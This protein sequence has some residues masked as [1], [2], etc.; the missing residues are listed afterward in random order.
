MCYDL[1][2]APEETS[3]ERFKGKGRSR[4]A[5]RALR[6]KVAAIADRTVGYADHVCEACVSVPLMPFYCSVLFLWNWNNNWRR[7]IIISASS[8]GVSVELMRLSEKMAIIICIFF[9]DIICGNF[10]ALKIIIFILFIISPRKAAIMR[11]SF[12]NKMI[13]SWHAL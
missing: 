8:F 7:L 9:D 4:P 10:G 5:V 6:S 11:V 13:V 3:G 2:W 12:Y 1:L